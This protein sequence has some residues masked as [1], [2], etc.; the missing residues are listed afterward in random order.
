MVR[1]SPHQKKVRTVRSAGGRRRYD[2]F[3]RS[4]CARLTSQLANVMPTFRTGKKLLV[5]QLEK[6]ELGLRELR[7]MSDVE[8]HERVDLRAWTTL[9]VGG[10]AGLVSRCHSATGVRDTLDL[11]A[12]HG[13]G[14]VTLGGGSRLIASDSGIRVPV[15]SLTGSLARWE[16]ELEGIVA[17]GGANL[18]QVCRAAHRKGLSGLEVIG[19]SN[20][21]IGGLIRGGM[22]GLTRIGG[23]IDWIDLQR[24]GSGVDRWHSSASNPVPH[25]DDLHRGVVLRV[26]FKLRPSGL[27]EIKPRSAGPVKRRALRSTG[28]V[29]LDSADATAADLLAEAGCSNTGVGGVRLG[30][31]RGNELIAGRSASSVDVI[32]L[33]RKARDRVLASTGI[34]LITALVFIDENGLEI[35]L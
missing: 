20:Y 9:G 30:G 4:L 1:A 33:C 3:T 15:I 35:K 7:R 31:P 32:D 2:A 8:L 29:F 12:S 24:P 19:R 25:T 6:L 34:E 18:A 22:D 10:V 14:W 16:P 17:G 11:A 21:S 13:L 5:G 27:A 26:R 23:V 28:P